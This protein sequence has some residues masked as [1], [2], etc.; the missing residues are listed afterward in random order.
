MC[1]HG[2]SGSM[3]EQIAV[4]LS[5]RSLACGR[6]TAAGWGVAGGMSADAEGGGGREGSEGRAAP[7]LGRPL[8]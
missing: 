2:S 8:T 3:G 4:I 7:C 6:M 1:R 5:H